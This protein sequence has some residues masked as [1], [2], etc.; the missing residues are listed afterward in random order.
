MDINSTAQSGSTVFTSSTQ[1]ERSALGILGDSVYVSY[2][3]HYGDCKTFYGWVVKVVL[4][5]PTNVMAW[6]TTAKGGGSWSVG[7]V[8]SDGVSTFVATGNTM[9]V[10]TWSGGEAII[11][12]QPGAMFSGLT[13]DYW[14]PTNWAYL[15]L[16]DRDLGG[17]GR[18]VL[19][20]PRRRC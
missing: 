10:S 15:D 11:R 18:L 3:G 16:H 9:G 5:T 20:V 13:N 4:D 6:A 14:S 17:S 8:S 7:G 1:N 12:L 19:D 2:G